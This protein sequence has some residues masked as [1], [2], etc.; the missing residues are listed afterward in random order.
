MNTQGT[1]WGATPNQREAQL[2]STIEAMQAQIAELQET[3]HQRSVR[4]RQVLPSPDRFSGR[5]KD[6]DAWV[7]AMKAKLKVDGQAIGDKNAQFYYVYSSLNTDIQSTVLAFV[8]QAE[9]QGDWDPS[10]LLD[11]LERIF[12]DPNKARKAGQRLRELQQGTRTLSAYLPKFEKTLYEAGANTWPDDAKITTLMG[13]LNKEIKR[14]LGG[15][16]NLPTT[17]NEF[18]RVL[19]ALGDQQFDPRPSYQGNNTMDWEHTKAAKGKLAPAV[20]TAQRQQWREEGKCVRCGSPGHWVQKCKLQPTR[21]RSSST[22]STHSEAQ[23]IQAARGL[24]TQGPYQGLKTTAKRSG[25]VHWNDM[26]YDSDMD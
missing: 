21:S 12:D 23:P 20:S 16:L 8:Q 15:Q 17:Y 3:M 7:L 22:S 19:L 1:Q 14:R 13:G 25:A 6:W 11:H 9:K 10:H 26:E 18:I 5:A 4:P 24:I 2:M